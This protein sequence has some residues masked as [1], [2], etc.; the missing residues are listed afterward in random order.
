MR[1]SRSLAAIFAACTLTFAA[2]GGDDTP[3][4]ST[5]DD[6]GSPS[7]GTEEDEQPDPGAE[8]APGG[9]LADI[10][11]VLTGEEVGAVLGGPVTMAEAGGV[12]CVFSP[13][14]PTAPSA[15][16][17]LTALDEGAGGLEGVQA[18]ITSAV[19]GEVEDLAGVG[20]EAF[21][22][23]GP[24]LGG[25]VNQGA[26]AVLLDATVAQVTVLQGQQLTEDE[27]KQ[28]TVGML[29]LIGSKA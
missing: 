4:P 15:V 22:V 17:N 25:S 3:A 14:D 13:E 8:E 9:G 6:V 21:V 18:G 29:E 2:C 19:E 7:S 1:P 27:V 26:G 10:C 24:V 23:V 28:L 16:V 11:G 5:G 12:G 20:D